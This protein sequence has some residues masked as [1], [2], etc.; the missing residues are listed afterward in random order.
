[1]KTKKIIFVLSTLFVTV[2][3]FLIVQNLFFSPKAEVKNNDND[4]NITNQKSVLFWENKIEEIGASEAYKFLKDNYLPNPDL[5]LQ[6]EMAHFF[7]EALYKKESIKGL[8]YCDAS[9][10]F[11]CYHSFFGFALLDKGLSVIH[12]LDQACIEAYGEKGLGCQ[13]G[14]GHGVLIELGYENFE[15]ALEEC[16]KLNWQGPIGG[17]T[18]GV[19]MEYN[20]HTMEENN[21]RKLDDRGEFFPC[22]S[23]DKKF[24][25]GCY[26]EQPSWWSALSNKDFTYVGQN[27]AMVEPKAQKDDCFKG[28]GNVVAGMF[29]YDLKIIKE[30]CSLMP[31]ID[32]EVECIVGAAWIVSNQP[33]YSNTWQ[34]LC[35]GYESNHLN[36]CL[37]SF[38]FI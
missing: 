9:F 17:C 6:H 19:F 14:L 4:Q 7:G 29:N 26:F 37:A 12:D 31:E 11:G 38:G 30:K 13:H 2:I 21:V 33:G 10:G 28:V 15:Q 27:C 24:K 36:R 8:V 1:M 22:N 23:V 20:H 18:S 35:E 3:L 34:E 32:N 25:S 5:G 16:S